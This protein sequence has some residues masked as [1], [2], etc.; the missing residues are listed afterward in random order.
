LEGIGPWTGGRSQVPT[1]TAEARPVP[2]GHVVLSTWRQQIDDGRGQDGM[3]TYKATARTA[4][5]RASQQTLDAAG[6]QP[7]DMGQLVTE[8]GSVALPT[9][10]V[11][12]PDGVV[13]APTNSAGLP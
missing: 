9:L 11:D 7:G 10:A 3:D 5:I 6:I 8:A 13:W 12:M 2:D 1:V 4:I